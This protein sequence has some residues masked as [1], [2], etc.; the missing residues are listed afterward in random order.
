MNWIKAKALNF[1]QSVCW[2]AW[3]YARKRELARRPWHGAT[4][5][6]PESPT[7]EQQRIISNEARQLLENKHFRDAFAAVDGY[8]EAQALSC[9]PDQP[10]KARRIV[11]AKQL[12]TGIRREIVRKMEDG[13]MAETMLAEIE[14]KRRARRI[15]R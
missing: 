10:E 13:I 6:A 15:V 7:Y 2:H 14:Q 12:L 11:I 8:L 5:E 4:G 1:W 9:D 3:D